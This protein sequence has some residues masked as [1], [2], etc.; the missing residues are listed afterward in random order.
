MLGSIFTP[1]AL[2]TLGCQLAV[3]AWDDLAWGPL[4]LISILKLVVAPAVTWGLALAVGLP[5]DLTDLFVVAAAAPVGVLL[6]VFC[7]EFGR[8]PKFVASAV[9]VT[10]LLSP[11]VVTAW[12]LLMRV[13]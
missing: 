13:T 10:T 6:A 9:L 4:T 7:A 8:E 11:V 5:G 12:L 1:L 2:F 3:S